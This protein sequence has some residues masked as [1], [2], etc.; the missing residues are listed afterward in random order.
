M[1]DRDPARSPTRRADAG[2]GCG[3]SCGARRAAVAATLAGRHCRGGRVAGAGLRPRASSST[4]CATARAVRDRRRDRRRH[5]RRR[6]WSAACAPAVLVPDRPARRGHARRPA[7]AHRRPGAA[8]P[9][10]VLERAGQGRP[11]VAGR[12]R[13]RGD[14]QGRLRRAARTW[15]RRSCWRALSLAAMAGIDWRLG[16]AGAVA[17]PLYAL[18]L[19]WYLPR[20]AP[21]VRRGA[22]GGRRAVAGCWSRACRAPRTV[23]AYRLEQRHLAEIDAASAQARDIVVGVFTLFTRFVGPG[24]PGRV[25]RARGDPGG[26]LPAGARRLGHR[27]ADH[28]RGAAVPPAVQ[29]DRHA[30]VH[31]R[32]DPGGGREPGPAG[33]RG[34]ASPTERRP[35]PGA[36]PRGRRRWT[37]TD[38]GFSYDGRAAGA[39][40][41]RACACEPGERVALVGS[42]G[43]GKTTVAA[44]AAGIAAPGARRGAHRRRAAC[45]SSP[46]ARAGGDR[47]PGDARLRRAADRGPAAGPAGRHRRR[48]GGGAGHRRRAATGCARCPTASTPWSAK[49]ATS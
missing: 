6:R 5:R 42:T 47:Q 45:R 49:A 4:G 17:V 21:A 38:V 46:P 11:A 48:G 3:P 18:A 41:R 39:A 7:G 24:Q 25:L 36:A 30:A 13:R 14:R 44:I 2:P 20:S 37:W 8:L 29:P 19:R 43:A 1:S 26:R 16:L 31:L 12:R 10:H 22:R 23:H 27:R 34:R 40:R 33:R 28:R 32:R 15:S 9:R 35:R